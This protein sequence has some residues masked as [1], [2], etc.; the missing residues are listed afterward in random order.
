MPA[1]L[2][3]PKGYQRLGNFPLDDT[4]VFATKAELDTY[5]SSNPTAYTGQICSVAATGL[6]YVILSD[7]SLSQIGSSGS[8]ASHTQDISTI[9]G[10]Q[11]QLDAKQTKTVYSDTAPTHAAGLEW[12]DTTDLRSYRSYNGAWIEID[13]A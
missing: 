5:A 6:V 3:L 1:P 10:L 13:R 7:K 8:V 9:N 4:F 12:V 11:A 2:S